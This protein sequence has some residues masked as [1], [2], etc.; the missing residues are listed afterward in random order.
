MTELIDDK[1]QACAYDF[2]TGHA[3]LNYLLKYPF[4]TLKI[5]KEFVTAIEP[6]TRS[7]KIV[8]GI[9]SL[10]HNFGIEV[11]AEGWKPSPNWTG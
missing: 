10:A 3:N 8:E 5:D 9:I 1:G 7:T 4:D 11:L 2:G 6:D